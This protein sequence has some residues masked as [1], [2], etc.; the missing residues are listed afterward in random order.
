MLSERRYT[1]MDAGIG[2]G[3]TWVGAV[4][5]IQWAARGRATGMITAPTYRMLIDTTIPMWRS[6]AEPLGARFLRSDMLGVW[7]NGHVTLFRS[8]EHPDRLRGPTLSYWWGDEAALYGPAVFPIAQGRLREVADAQAWLTTT[9]KGRAHWIWRELLS[10]P[11]PDVLRVS[12]ETR[13]NPHLPDTYIEDVYNAYQGDYARQELAG[14]WVSWEGLIADGFEYR[15]HVR[16]RHGPWKRVAIGADDGYTNPAALLVVAWDGRD[17][18]HILAEWYER[19]RLQEEIA[20]EAAELARRYSATAVYPDPASPGLAEA[21]RRAGLSVR[22]ADNRVREGIQAIQM[23]INSDPPVL[24]V[25]PACVH[26]IAEFGAW[27]WRPEKG[28]IVPEQELD[29][30]NHAMAAL[31]YALLSQPRMAES[32]IVVAR[33]PLAEV[34]TP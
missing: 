33:D 21:M 27:Q 30:N 26:T 2:A 29:W 5:A 19:R 22:A 23:R 28:I 1:V 31:R 13:D 7:P 17:N 11:R 4:K 15:T 25:D 20:A 8:T 3:K 6:L 32:H 16:R 24:T 12:A 18:A 9:P 10:R 14:E 34:E